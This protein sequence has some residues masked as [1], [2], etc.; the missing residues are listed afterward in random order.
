MLDSPAPRVLGTPPSVR[1]HE[2][3]W[4][5]LCSLSP[6]APKASLTPARVPY[7]QPL[8]TECP[9][10]A[11]GHP[12]AEAGGSSIA[13]ASRRINGRS[14]QPVGPCDTSIATQHFLQITS[15]QATCGRRSPPSG[16]AP[17]ETVRDS[18]ARSDALRQL[19][20][21]SRHPDNEASIVG[22]VP[23]FS[24]HSGAQSSLAGEYAT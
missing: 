23:E 24:A 11:A 21:L 12:L 8:W 4:A 7:C 14:P 22:D 13:P 17:T 19:L 10:L 18:T 6:F 9:E 16:P 5:A 15:S 1:W 3:G 20:P 2:H